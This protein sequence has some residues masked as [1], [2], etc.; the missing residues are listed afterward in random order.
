LVLTDTSLKIKHSL[1]MSEGDKTAG[2]LSRPTPRVD[3]EDD[4]P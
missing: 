1:A 4:E 2:A 3:A